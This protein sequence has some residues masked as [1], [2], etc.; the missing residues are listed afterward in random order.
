MNVKLTI[1][2]AMLLPIFERDNQV[3]SKSRKT[4]SN[5]GFGIDANND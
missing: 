1:S 5:F 3:K 2:I 4:S